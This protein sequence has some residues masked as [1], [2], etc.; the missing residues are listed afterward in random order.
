MLVEVRQRV[1]G[2]ITAGKTINETGGA[3]PTRDF[4]AAWGGGYVTP[5]V[6]IRMVFTSLAGGAG[7]DGR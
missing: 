4:D 6:F 5:E 2:F 7:S 3:A 1:K